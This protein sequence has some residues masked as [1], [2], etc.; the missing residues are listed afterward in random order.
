MS[1]WAIVVNELMR[2]T[3]LR[4]EVADAFARASCLV[5]GTFRPA[6][7]GGSAIEDVAG[8]IWRSGP[9]AAAR[10]M[11]ISKR[12]LNRK[13]RR[14]FLQ[15]PAGRHKRGR[16]NQEGESTEEGMKATNRLVRVAIPAGV[17]LRIGMLVMATPGR[18]N[19]DPAQSDIG[20]QPLP[21]AL[22]RLR[23]PGEDAIALSLRCRQKRDGQ[24][25]WPDSSRSTLPGADAA[26]DRAGGDLQRR[27]HR[28]HSSCYHR[29]KARRCREQ[30]GA[31]LPRHLNLIHGVPAGTRA[32]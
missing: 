18:A 5:G 28:D 19:A 16:A 25:R 21:E 23:G 27:G 8:W 10:I 9:A 17:G 32:T 15:S 3:S 13:N 20:P 26:R 12:Q 24:S 1:R 2:Y 22:K 30:R 11:S 29:E 31:Q 7:R 14:G 6:R 4:I